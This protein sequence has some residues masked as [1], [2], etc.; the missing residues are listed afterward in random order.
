[1]TENLA[2]YLPLALRIGA[3]EK[4]CFSQIS[5]NLMKQ[6]REKD[7]PKIFLNQTSKITGA[8]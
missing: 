2:K 8:E 6:S 1:M 7:F 5:Q 4:P 3:N